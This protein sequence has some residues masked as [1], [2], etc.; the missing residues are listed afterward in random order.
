[1]ITRP[2]PAIAV[3]C[4]ARR[5][6]ER[7]FLDWP[8]WDECGS[9]RTGRKRKR[10]YFLSDVSETKPELTTQEQSNGKW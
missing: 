1:M 2:G 5:A 6:T 8:L 3:D 7:S 10:N 9:A 4:V